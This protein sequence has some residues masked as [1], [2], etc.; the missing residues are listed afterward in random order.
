MDTLDGATLSQQLLRLGLLSEDQLRDVREEAGTRDPDAQ[1]LIRILERKTLLTPWQ[2]TKLLKGEVEGL[3][4]GG[5]RLLYRISSGS[6]GRVYRAED[7]NTGRVVAVKVLRRRWSEDTHRIELFVREAQVGMTLKHNNIVEVL[8][9]G[10]DSQS[11]QY[12]IVMEFVEGQNLR[13][14]LQIRKTLPVTTAL[15]VAEDAASGLAYAHSRG[16]THRDIKPTNLLISSIGNTKLVDFGLA[17]VTA[18]ADDKEDRGDGRLD[19]TVDYA[20]L[21]RATGAKNGDPRSDIYFLGC[22]V[23]EMLMGKPPL[24]PTK[25]K[26]ARMQ[27]YRFDNLLH[28]Q[29]GQV[30]APPGFYLLVDTMTAMSPQH[31]FQTAAQLLD[32]LKT[33]RR[34]ISGPAAGSGGAGAVQRSLFIV[35]RN[36]KLQDALR[37]KFKELGYRVFMAGDPMRALDR[38]RQQ[39]F[40]CLIIDVGTAG[41]EALLIFD[42]IMIE[43][44]FKRVPC[45]G[46]A[47]LSEE[48]A[49]LAGRVKPRP[50]QAVLVRPVTMK[51]L[52]RKLEELL[53]EG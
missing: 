50:Q 34:E 3:T 27:R 40:Q 15:R 2:S 36:E 21:E 49:D 51:S 13:E 42:Q 5:Y 16:Y 47:I 44:Q 6:F 28:L 12:Y 52:Q 35:E 37:E 26:N 41:E 11:K 31:R 38:F 48:Q 9:M 24:A 53:E 43:A 33:L 20:G 39:P 23:Y 46:I 1:T 32:S 7:P 8:A 19:R 45:T 29:P 30:D 17:G 25:D 22:V 4:L 18:G 14:L 10:Q